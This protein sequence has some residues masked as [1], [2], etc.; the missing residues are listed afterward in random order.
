MTLL[1]TVQTVHRMNSP[2][3]K[4]TKIEEYY[5]MGDTIINTAHSGVIDAVI[6]DLLFQVRHMVRDSPDMYRIVHILDAVGFI[7]DSFQVGSEK[8]LDATCT[9]RKC[10]RKYIT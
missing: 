2:F 4:G 10:I 1:Q 6:S 8:S 9:S 7:D 5:C 3:K